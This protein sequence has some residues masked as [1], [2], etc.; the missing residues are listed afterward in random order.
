MNNN[1]HQGT[2]TR[3]Q[4]VNTTLVEKSPSIA[5]N[6]SEEQFLEELITLHETIL[7]YGTPKEISETIL[8]KSNSFLEL[9][10][11]TNLKLKML[12]LLLKV[13]NPSTFKE[14]KFII[15]L[16]VV[17]RLFSI[18]VNDQF[19]EA[20]E[21]NDIIHNCQC[22]FR[23]KAFTLDQL[24]IVRTLTSHYIQSGKQFFVMTLDIKNV[25]GLVFFSKFKDI[26]NKINFSNNSSETIMNILTGYKIKVLV[27]GKLSKQFDS[28]LGVPQGDPSSLLLF[29]I[30][31]N[32]LTTNLKKYKGLQFDNFSVS[33]L[34]YADD[35]IV[36]TSTY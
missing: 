14:F 36:I 17:Y 7:S 21:T 1:N 29:N 33:I 11:Q 4:R 8:K 31:F 9:Y 20:Y 27:K 15:V 3:R 24:I 19:M 18:I 35:I 30:Y 26:L 23:R 12:L 32:V 10:Q 13:I 16:L 34:K 2:S 5:L 22:G 6:L 25:Y 28:T